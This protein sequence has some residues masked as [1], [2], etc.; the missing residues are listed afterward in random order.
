MRIILVVDDNQ[1]VCKIVELHSMVYVNYLVSPFN[2][3]NLPRYV[4]SAQGFPA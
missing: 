4:F 3:L 1:L 2:P